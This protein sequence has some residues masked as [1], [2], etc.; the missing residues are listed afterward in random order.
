APQAADS[1]T[2]QRDALQFGSNCRQI[3]G[4]SEDCLFVNVFTPKLPN[5]DDNSLL[6]VLFVI[7]GGAFIGRSGDLKPGHMMDKGL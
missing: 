1:W 4:G 6:P 7:H 5:E 2:G 3:R